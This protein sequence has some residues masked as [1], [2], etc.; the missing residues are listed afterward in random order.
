LG[1]RSKYNAESRLK[2]P[3][4]EMKAPDGPTTMQSMHFLTQQGCVVF[5]WEKNHSHQW[6]KDRLK[7][8]TETIRGLD[9]NRNQM[10]LGEQQ[11]RIMEEEGRTYY[12]CL[13][14]SLD[15]PHATPRNNTI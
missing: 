11:Q 4:D 8:D 5:G 2:D 9:K 15:L 13:L 3:K 7:L 12:F 6:R 14:L 1:N 10:L